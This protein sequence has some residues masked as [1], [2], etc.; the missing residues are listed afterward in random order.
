MV[1]G[2]ARG[3]TTISASNSGVTGSTLLNVTDKSFSN[4]SLNGRYAFT[5]TSP[6][7]RGP[8]VESGSIT[9]NGN[10]SIASGTEDANTAA[11]VSHSAV[12][13]TYAIQA[14][15]RGVVFLTINSATRSFNIAL[16]AN[17]ATS[18]DNSGE[19]I[20][21]DT[22]ANAIGTL[23]PQDVSAFN[24]AALAS[25]TFAFRVGGNG[26][27]SGPYL[28]RLGLIT[29]D[30]AGTN[31]TGRDDISNGGAMTSNPVIT[32]TMGAVDSSTGRVTVALDSA[33]Y[34]AYV[35]SSS[36]LHIIGVDA[37]DALADRRAAIKTCRP[38][39]RAAT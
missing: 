25:H 1:S 29:T 13:G 17:S 3:V 20:Q 12:T 26:F 18:G 21:S 35:V 30:A 27:N 23:E 19:L 33:N 14:D 34:V 39:W 9:A 22:Q 8:G 10:G 38:F 11:G 2:I 15:G 7:S 4:A 5:L 36:K 31:L 28:S 24:N 37:P 32:G 6:D 16:K